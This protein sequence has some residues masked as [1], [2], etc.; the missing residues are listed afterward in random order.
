MSVPADSHPADSHPADSHPADSHAADI[1]T[2]DDRATREKLLWLCEYLDDAT[3]YTADI[4]Y[5]V[6][7][8]DKF[9]QL[10]I[11]LAARKLSGKSTAATW[12]SKLGFAE[13]NNADPLK[14]FAMLSGFE[15]HEVYGTDTQ[16]ETPSA[17]MGISGRQ[18]LQQMGTDIVRNHVHL[19]PGL[20]LD[21]LNFWAFVTRNRIIKSQNRLVAVGD[22]RFQDEQKMVNALHGYTIKI[23]RHM[24]RSGPVHQH[25]SEQGIDAMVTNYTIENNGTLDEFYRKLARA[26]AACINDFVSRVR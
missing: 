16:K 25:P 17:L 21:S 11:A 5:Y 24:D 6:N 14:E 23:E 20:K 18:F 4:D 7:H 12:L 10:V 2:M 13:F 8:L 19:C 3:Q 1:H 9:P 26:T 22:L 15:R